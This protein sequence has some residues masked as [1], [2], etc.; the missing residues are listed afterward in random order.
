MAILNYEKG[1]KIQLSGDFHT[2]EFHC[3]GKN[4]CV[5]TLVDARLVEYLQQIR[6]HFCAPVILNS[7][8]RCGKH[9]EAVGGA[10][11]SRHCA[12]MAAD[13][14][15]KGY[16]PLE[17]A[18]YAEQIGIPGIGLYETDADGHFVHIDTREKKCYW[19]GQEQKH[20]DTFLDGEEVFSVKLR[21]L[22]KGSRGEDVAALQYL[23]IARGYFC[24][25]TG[26]DGI[27]GSGTEGALRQCQRDHGLT[28][29]GIAGYETMACLLGMKNDE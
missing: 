2:G 7:G 6:D 9:N 28:E 10:K 20:R 27:F 17:V 25:D 18:Q 26:A 13:I 5:E 3:K 29:D 12:G 4:C 1:S 21:R 16:K 8:Y 14:R 24:G 23:L 15:V 19:Y 22:C 11:N